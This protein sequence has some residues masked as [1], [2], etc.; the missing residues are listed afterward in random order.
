[1]LHSCRQL[2][3]A[4]LEGVIDNIGAYIRWIDAERL[5]RGVTVR[6]DYSMRAGRAS[7]LMAILGLRSTC[8]FGNVPTFGTNA[9]AEKIYVPQLRLEILIPV[10]VIIAGFSVAALLSKV[11]RRAG[12]GTLNTAELHHP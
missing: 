7:L 1:V 8:V 6:E 5:T 4:R 10:A 11:R 2:N 3:A 12:H 9:A